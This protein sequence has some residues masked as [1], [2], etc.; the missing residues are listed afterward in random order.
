MRRTV[1]F[2]HYCRYHWEVATQKEEEAG[3]LG[4]AAYARK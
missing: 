1:R 4:A 3:N 2:F